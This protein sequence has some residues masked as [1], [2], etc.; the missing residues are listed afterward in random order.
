MTPYLKENCLF[1]NGTQTHKKIFLSDMLPS[2]PPNTFKKKP[3]RHKNR[4]VTE[5]SKPP[6]R[7]E[8]IINGI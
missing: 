2:C 6:L 1:L 7:N 8:T 3:R 5:I 4:L